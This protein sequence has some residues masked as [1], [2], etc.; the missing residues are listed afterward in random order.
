MATLKKY[1]CDVCGYV[2]DPAIGD[3][4]AGIQP[5]TSFEDLPED[6]L[7]PLCGVGKEEFSPID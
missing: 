2:Y 3:E 1:E 6:W 5:G 4:D 7:C